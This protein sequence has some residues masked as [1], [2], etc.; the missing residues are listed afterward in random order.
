MLGRVS[1][2]IGRRPP[3]T[4]VPPT[5]RLENPGNPGVGVLASGFPALAFPVLAFPASGFPVLVFPA[6]AFTVMVGVVRGQGLRRVG[7]KISPRRAR[8]T[9]W[10]ERDR[11]TRR[12]PSSR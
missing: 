2:R 1:R 9:T 6:S 12:G 4:Y 3:P 11:R 8:S 7:V 5:R 10:M